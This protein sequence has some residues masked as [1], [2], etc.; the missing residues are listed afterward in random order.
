MR[1]YNKLTRIIN[2]GKISPITYNHFYTF[3]PF[4]HRT[5]YLDLN[6][7]LEQ[8]QP[9]RFDVSKILDICNRSSIIKD[10]NI[11]QEKIRNKSQEFG[12]GY[13]ENI[14]GPKIY[15]APYGNQ[16]DFITNIENYDNHKIISD[17]V[18]K[19]LW[20]K[21]LAIEVCNKVRKYPKQQ[22]IAYIPEKNIHQIYY[23]ANNYDFNVNYAFIIRIIEKLDKDNLVDFGKFFRSGKDVFFD[24]DHVISLTFDENYNILKSS[25]CVLRIPLDEYVKKGGKQ[26]INDSYI[27]KNKPSYVNITYKK[28]YYDYRPNYKL[29]EFSVNYLVKDDDNLFLEKK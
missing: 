26:I 19:L 2:G 18:Q 4:L 3:K 28:S 23:F 9:S 16:I 27:E 5:Q 22:Y 14:H 7:P 17:D 12:I 20:E 6:K 8:V 21:W 15:L 25:F 11:I 13:G 29:S 1:L 24:R 10:S